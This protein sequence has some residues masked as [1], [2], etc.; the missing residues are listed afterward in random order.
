MIN[1]EKTQLFLEFFLSPVCHFFRVYALSEA[2]NSRGRRIW[3]FIQVTDLEK[4][5]YETLP[6]G[7]YFLKNML[8]LIDFA[9]L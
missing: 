6:A 9:R 2:V 8:I 1:D 5:F 4:A 3:V 7:E